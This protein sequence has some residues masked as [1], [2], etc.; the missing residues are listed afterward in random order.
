MR[1]R[2]RTRAFIAWRDAA[3]AASVD[4]DERYRKLRHLAA[5]LVAMS[6]HGK[7]AAW[8]RW[9]LFVREQAAGDS[10]ESV[11]DEASALRAQLARRAKMTAAQA[12]GHALLHAQNRRMSRA[13]HAWMSFARYAAMAGADKSM[14][15][16]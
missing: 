16:Q 1:L 10:R 5:A 6:R 8:T 15:V 7:M 3:E 2:H 13:W 12:I 11:L 4:E 14:A 9:R